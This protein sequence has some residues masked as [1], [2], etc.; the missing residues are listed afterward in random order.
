M[1]SAM[2]QPIGIIELLLQ[3]VGIIELLLQSVQHSAG[4]RVRPRPRPYTAF[5]DRH[6][7][8]TQLWA[9]NSNRTYWAILA[10]QLNSRQRSA[11][12]SVQQPALQ[13]VQPPA[14][15]MQRVS[16]TGGSPPVTH[17]AN[18][19]RHTLP[20]SARDR[21]ELVAR[22]LFEVESQRIT[23]ALHLHACV[24]ACVRTCRDEC[25]ER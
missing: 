7:P 25:A 18:H 5:R 3:S 8:N 19:R 13:S 15:S 24:R 11:Q 9:S 10:A 16:A 20:A 14:A 17:K 1:H 2:P 22:A 12:Q 21:W 4:T 23:D 6:P